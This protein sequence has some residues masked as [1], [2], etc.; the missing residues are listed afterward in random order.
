MKK[1]FL[2]LIAVMA[3]NTS[4]LFS[5]SACSADSVV[6]VVKWLADA[7]ADKLKD[8][9]IDVDADMKNLSENFAVYAKNHGCADWAFKDLQES[10]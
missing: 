8:R 1:L 3:T 5:D 9:G 2:A 7:T 10:Y 6:K 4:F